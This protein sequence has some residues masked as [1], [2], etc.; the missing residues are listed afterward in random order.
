MENLG[1]VGEA[2]KKRITEVSRRLTKEEI[3]FLAAQG[4]TPRGTGFVKDNKFVSNEL[5]DGIIADFRGKQAVPVKDKAPATAVGV[6]GG[7]GADPIFEVVSS[8]NESFEKLF[9]ILV[10][11]TGE[12]PEAQAV[13]VGAEKE[14]VDKSTEGL[15]SL[16]GKFKSLIKFGAAFLLTVAYPLYQTIKDG[17]LS[18]IEFGGTLVDTFKEKVFPFFTETLPQIFDEVKIFF[19]EKLPYYFELFVIAAK[20]AVMSILE[21]PKQVFLYLENYAIDFGKSILGKFEPWLSKIGIDTKAASA[22]LDEKQKSVKKEQELADKKKLE[23]EAARKAAE[24][25]ARKQYEAQKKAREEAERKAAAKAAPAVPA[26]P[27][28]KPTKEAAPALESVTAKASGVNTNDLSPVLKERVAK[29]AAD[30]NEKTGKKLLI[31]SG[32]RSNE[33]QQ[34]LWEKELARQ[35]GNV[36]EA[37]KMVAPPPPIGK[38]SKHAS[39][40]AIDINSKGDAGLNALAGDRTKPTGWLEGFGLTRPVNN[41]NWHVQLVGDAPVADNPDQPG[42]PTLIPGSTKLLGDG[43][44]KDV[45]AEYKS[46]TEKKPTSSTSAGPS[47]PKDAD[48]VLPEAPVANAIKTA[49]NKVG[50]DVA[51]MYAMAKQE[52][53]FNPAAKA[54]GTTATGLYQF[55]KGTWAGMV[56]AYGS[57]F[58][59]LSRG[60]LDP[61]ANAIA[62]ALYIQDNS[63]LLSKKGIPI[64]ATT[65][66]AA[67]FLGGSGAVKLLSAPEK[68]IGA[69]VLPDAA[70]SN[71][72]IF[73]NKDNE[74]K[75]RTVGEIIQILYGKVGQYQEKY[76]AVITPSM[77]TGTRVAEATKAADI[78]APKVAAASPQPPGMRPSEIKTAA[79]GGGKDQTASAAT[80]VRGYKSYFAVS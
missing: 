16:F 9:G 42:K 22:A 2:L 44:P 59:E 6:T 61:L 13:A 36:A 26:P 79:A 56:K 48:L 54:K 45:T 23:A 70:A 10:Q 64:T 73:Y 27:P 71:K 37:R 18:L 3:E 34:E 62:G 28:A 52:S 12:K 69:E 39:G 80:V 78:K 53:G 63:K 65:I 14:G 74:N 19:T 25:A 49:A 68:S 17:V 11:P 21:F 66:Y 40:V 67:H 75:P 35:G 55:L 57:K 31:T 33:Q 60:P 41:E 38:G 43:K 5:I 15:S 4:I 58:P 50:V 24:E 72:S 51:I 1:I 77:G 32:Y 20:D 30:F 76:A 29:M 8:I 47:Q 7:G 46:Q